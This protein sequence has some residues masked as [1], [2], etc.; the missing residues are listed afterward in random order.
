MARANHVADQACY[1]KVAD[2]LYE[3]RIQA[4]ITYNAMRQIK[5]TKAQAR[6][7]RL[8]KEQFLTVLY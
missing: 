2:M 6:D 5:V 1:K 4:I 8:T 3:A 7:M